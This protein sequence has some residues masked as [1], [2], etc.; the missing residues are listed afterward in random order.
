MFARIKINVDADKNVAFYRYA[1]PLTFVL[2][3]YPSIVPCSPN[4]PPRWLINGNWYV[5]D[6]HVSPSV[7]PIKLST[8]TGTKFEAFDFAG[9]LRGGGIYSAEQIAAHKSFI[10]RTTSRRAVQQEMTNRMT[11][12]GQGYY[13]TAPLTQADFQEMRDHMGRTFFPFVY[14]IGEK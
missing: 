2:S 6:P 13:F 14:W 11:R 9:G 8:D 4:M 1:D 3:P 7:A 10:Q 5:A 12:G